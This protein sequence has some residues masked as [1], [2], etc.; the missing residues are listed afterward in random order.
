MITDKRPLTELVDEMLKEQNYHPRDYS[1][2]LI[3]Q[4][5][6]KNRIKYLISQV[7]MQT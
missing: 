1:F 5:Y 3:T 6:P 4:K 2:R 7:N